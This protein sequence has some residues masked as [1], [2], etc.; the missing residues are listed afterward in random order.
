[1]LQG[2][3][4]SIFDFRI[5]VFARQ[6]SLLGQLGRITEVAKRGQWFVAS[7]TRRL[8]EAEVSALLQVTV[9]KLVLTP[10]LGRP[11]GAFYRKLD[12]YGFDGHCAEM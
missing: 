9:V 3:A 4:I 2:S 6:A 8:K 7:L 1:M 10:Y 11:G 12:V 5:Y